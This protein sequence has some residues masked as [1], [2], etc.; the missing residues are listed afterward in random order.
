MLAG[1]VMWG[2]VRYILSQFFGVP[3]SWELFLT[4]A[5]VS[6]I[7]GIILQVILIPVLVISLKREILKLEE[8]YI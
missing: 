2:S 4:G 5:F 7:P 1:R 3:F 8:I 6:A